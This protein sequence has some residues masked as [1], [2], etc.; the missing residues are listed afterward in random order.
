[1]FTLS[2]FLDQIEYI[3]ESPERVPL[4]EMLHDLSAVMS[5]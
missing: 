5:F 2:P 4:S 1:M 3:P